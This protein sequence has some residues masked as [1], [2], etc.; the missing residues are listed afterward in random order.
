MSHL[1]EKRTQQKILIV[2][3][4]TASGKSALA[5]QL[6]RR[7]HGEVISADSRQIY[8]GL[9]VGTGKITKKEMLGIPHHLLD[10]VDPKKSFSVSDY[11]KLAETK[12]EEILRRGKLP[13]I[14]GGTGFYIDAVTGKASLPEVPP[15]AVLRK[16]LEARTAEELFKELTK[17]DPVRAETIDKHNKVRLVRALEIVA[18]LGKVPPLRQG[19]AGQTSYEYIWIGLKPE[20]SEL[21]TKIEKRLTARLPKMIL[22]AKRLHAN[23]LSW[24]R[25]SE[26]GI[27]YKHLSAYLQKR[28]TKQELRDGILKDS[29]AYSK[30]QD[31][32]FKTNKGIMWFPSGASK[33]I[34]SYL[35]NIIKGV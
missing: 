11:K 19:S 34:E 33:E 6:A 12:I 7:F 1:M 15:N 35:T 22:E 13:I 14:A 24:K 3:G 30:R 32:W 23:G 8:K 25:M 17:K 16:K 4:P 10:I 5:V 28:I 27:E 29:I 26:V 21:E 31:T 2:V 20:K 18:A 9:D